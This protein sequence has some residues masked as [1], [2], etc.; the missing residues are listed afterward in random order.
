MGYSAEVIKRARLRLEQAKADRESE[1]RQHLQHAYER[2]PRI[3]E[4]DLKLRQTM[5]ET[6]LQI[7]QVKQEYVERAGHE[8]RDIREQLSET[9][10]RTMVARDVLDRTVVTAPGSAPSCWRMISQPARC[11][12]ISSWSAA[13]ARKVSPAQKRTRLPSFFSW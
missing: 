13:A 5:A 3:R 4:I 10:E 12:Q 8:L 11:A 2:V 7:V 1:N 9:T 6:R